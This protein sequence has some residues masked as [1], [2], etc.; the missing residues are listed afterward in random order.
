[1]GRRSLAQRC[2]PSAISDSDVL[3][4]RRVPRRPT[5][6]WTLL[7]IVAHALLAVITATEHTQQPAPAGLIALPCNEIRRLFT[8]Y[9]IEPARTMACPHAWSQW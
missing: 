9:V 3:G 8:I 5:G 6:R 2:A 7:A 1:M 4:F